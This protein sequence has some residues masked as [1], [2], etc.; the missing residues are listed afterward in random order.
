ML[1]TQPAGDVGPLRIEPAA[2]VLRPLTTALV[3]QVVS[4]VHATGLR[5]VSAPFATDG[6]LTPC[7]PS[8]AVKEGTSCMPLVQ[9]ADGTLARPPLERSGS[10]RQQS[11]DGSA[12]ACLCFGDECELRPSGAGRF[13]YSLEVGGQTLETAIDVL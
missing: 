12:T 8:S 1:T 4:P 6:A 7:A 11:P 2:E 10:L 3:V 9:L 5:L 13:A